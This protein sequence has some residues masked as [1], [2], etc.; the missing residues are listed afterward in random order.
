M[1]IE[2]VSTYPTNI[3]IRIKNGSMV[4]CSPPVNSTIIIMNEKIQNTNAGTSKK[5]ATKAAIG[6]VTNALIM[7]Y[8]RCL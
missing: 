5:G 3:A 8:A 6:D 1:I 2:I 4:G 7:I